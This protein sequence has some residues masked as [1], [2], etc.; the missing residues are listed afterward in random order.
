MPKSPA[1]NLALFNFLRVSTG[2]SSSI[3]LP[4]LIES[5]FAEIKSPCNCSHSD[6]G[7]A[8]A[9][10][11]VQTSS[12]DRGHPTRL[13]KIFLL[14]ILRIFTLILKPGCTLWIAGLSTQGSCSSQ[15]TQIKKSGLYIIDLPLFSS[16]MDYTVNIGIASH[17]SGPSAE[18]EKQW[19]QAGYNLR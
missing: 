6:Q 5:S 14:P 13:L 4:N 19:P 15:F 16:V 11:R 7:Q 12:S 18:G 9:F 1:N 8:A 10:L 3:I 2:R 17:S